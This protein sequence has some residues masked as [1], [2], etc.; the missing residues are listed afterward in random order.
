MA[1]Q[2]GGGNN[3]PQ[4]QTVDPQC[5]ERVYISMCLSL[6]IMSAIIQYFS[7]GLERWLSSEDRALGA[8]EEDQ[9]SIPTR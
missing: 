2:R 7:L 9:G 1:I 5:L 3:P 6:Q 8:F 4:L